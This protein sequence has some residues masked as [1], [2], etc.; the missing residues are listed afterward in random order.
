[1][2]NKKSK[3]KLIAEASNIDTAPE[4]LALLAQQSY[5]HI[6]VAANPS[7]PPRVLDMLSNS[8]DRD[9]RRAVALNPNTS[10]NRLYMMVTEFPDEF[11]RNPILP[12]L[13]MTQP[14]FIK[15]LSADAWLSLG[16]VANLPPSHLKQIENRRRQYRFDWS[17]TWQL[18]QLYLLTEIPEQWRMQANTWNRKYRERLLQSAPIATEDDVK[19]FLL[20]VMLCPVASPMLVE[21]WRQ[22]ARVAPQLVSS[23]LAHNV[24]VGKRTI[25]KLS[26]VLNEAV[27]QQAA[28]HRLL[29]ERALTRLA[30]HPNVQVRCSVAGNPHTPAGVISQLVWENNS[31][32]RRVAAVHPHLQQDRAV[33]LLHE[34]DRVRAALAALPQL[35]SEQASTLQNDAAEEVRAAL[36][37]NVKTP[38]EILLT[39]AG[40]QAA[41]VRAAAAS[42]P[43]L[44]AAAMQILLH[45]PVDGVRAGLSGN[46]RLPEACWTQLIHDP[47]LE[48]RKHLA[49]NPRLPVQ[50]L[51]QLVQTREMEVWCGVARHPQAS[52][53]LLHWLAQH[54][55]LQVRATVAAHKRAPVAVLQYLAQQEEQAIWLSLTTNPA[56]PLDILERAVQ[57]NDLQLWLRLLNHPQMMRQQRR[58]LMMALVQRVQ[59]LLTKDTLPNWLRHAVFQYYRVLPTLLLETFAASP[60]WEDRYLITHHPRIELS[61]LH[62]LA[63]DQVVY[64]RAAASEILERREVAHHPERPDVL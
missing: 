21:Q 43:C 2:F 15:Q 6:Y 20:F 9:V 16:R 38:P 60:Y 46:A 36:A 50:L 51:E 14:D 12:L 41:G 28:R 53:K 49:A 61:L 39:L 47:A 1:M 3:D 57:K 29:G 33:L 5:L 18:I 52:E 58:P 4:H 42:N 25:T 35:T 17:E 30:T 11:L 13:K 27:L 56:T 54:G 32:V 22:A 19:L 7:T 63:R 31:R 55:N 10:L 24:A 45:D 23:A 44:P 26:V 34:D 8:K 48:V 62:T 64:V 37:R 40:D 59:E